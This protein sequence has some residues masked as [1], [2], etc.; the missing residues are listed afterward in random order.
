MQNIY[1]ISFIFKPVLKWKWLEPKDLEI[2]K[3]DLD[4]KPVVPWKNK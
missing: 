2:K 4:I 3:I 1:N